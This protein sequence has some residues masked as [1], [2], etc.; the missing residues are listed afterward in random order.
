MNL[1][2]ERKYLLKDMPRVKPD[3]F[4]EI[5]QFYCENKRHKTKYRLR[6]INRWVGNKKE[7]TY[8][9]TIKRKI[10]NG[11]YE[12]HEIGLNKGAFDDL[13]RYAKTRL[14]KWRYI[15]KINKT[16]KWEVDIYRDMKLVIAEI[17]L[18]KKNHKFKIPDYIKNK[19]IMEVTEFD[20]FT[21]FNLSERI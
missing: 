13:F 6:I 14:S 4:M 20:E 10:E 18:P 3:D 21:N 7:T 16:L 1:E 12:E 11:V 9:Q 2:I 5:E 17:E 8:V 19:I 15:Y